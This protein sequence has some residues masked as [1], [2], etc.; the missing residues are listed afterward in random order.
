MRQTNLALGLLIV[1][2]VASAF[3]VPVIYMTSFPVFCTSYGHHCMGAWLP[4]TGLITYWLFGYGGTLS[5][6][7]YLV[8]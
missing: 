6:G 7:V 4:L 1:L 8:H 5:Q 2:V 3:F